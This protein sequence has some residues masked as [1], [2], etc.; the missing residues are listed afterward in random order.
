MNPTLVFPAAAP[1]CSKAWAKVSVDGVPLTASNTKFVTVGLQS[2]LQLS[3]LKLAVEGT[4][5]EFEISGACAT[6]PAFLGSNLS[7]SLGNGQVSGSWGLIEKVG[8]DCCW[9]GCS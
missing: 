7:Y 2:A 8:L 1:A 5:I 4:T 9:G 6:L 3:G